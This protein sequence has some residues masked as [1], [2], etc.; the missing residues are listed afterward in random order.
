MYKVHPGTLDVLKTGCALHHFITV[1]DPSALWALW[2]PW[3]RVAL[4]AP[5]GTLALLAL[6]QIGPPS[7]S[8]QEMCS[9]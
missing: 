4:L 6:A 7:L 2:A 5:L 8:W 3:P 9:R 1:P